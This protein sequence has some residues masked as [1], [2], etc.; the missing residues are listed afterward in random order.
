[1]V[2]QQPSAVPRGSRQE[3]AGPSPKRPCTSMH[4]RCWLPF[5]DLHL[6]QKQVTRTHSPL[7]GQCNVGHLCQPPRGDEDEVKALCSAGTSSLAMVSGT[8][9]QI[10]A[11]HLTGLQNVQADFTSRYL[12]DRTEWILNPWIFNILNSH[13]GLFT[14]D[15]FATCLSTQLPQFF[16]WRPDPEA[17]AT[18]ALIQDWQHLRGF[19]HPPWCLIGR[20]L[21]KV[22]LEGV[23]LVA[24]VWPSQPWYLSL[25]SLL[26]DFPVLLPQEPMTI[27]PSPNCQ[28][29]CRTTH[30]N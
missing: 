23:T 6:C 1:M 5:M 30:L 17:L 18:D 14:V 2:D 9:Y 4:K 29:P 10:T 24:P 22:R 19:V 25:L 3:V 26:V 13:W 27:S 15:L 28:N 7:I 20:V 8:T 11:Q 12:T 21:Q 16:S